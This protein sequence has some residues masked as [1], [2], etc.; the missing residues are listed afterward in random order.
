MG[1]QEVLC[2]GQMVVG[3]RESSLTARS[4]ARGSCR[5]PMAVLTQ[6]NG[7]LGDSMEKELLSQPKASLA[8]R[9]GR[10]V[11]LC[12]GWKNRQRSLERV[13]TR[14][15]RRAKM[16]LQGCYDKSRVR[17]RLRSITLLRL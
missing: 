14:N 10:M 17:H 9:N 11:T 15:R 7:K 13:E 5:G 8:N 4:M 1:D 2:D 3:T 6:V 12:G 16:K